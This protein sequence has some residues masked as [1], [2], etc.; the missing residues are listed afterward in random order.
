MGT[1]TCVPVKPKP[2]GGIDMTRLKKPVR[3]IIEERR[4]H[5]IGQLVLTLYPGGDLGIR[6]LGRRKEIR[7]DTGKLYVAAIMQEKYLKR[8]K[9]IRRIGK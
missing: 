6:E 1:V 2:Y 3:R 5:T 9:K 4:S 7:L 8:R